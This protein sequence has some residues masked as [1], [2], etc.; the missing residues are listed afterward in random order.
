MKTYALIEDG[1]VSQLVPP[2]VNPDGVD[3]PVEDR[4]TPDMVAMMVDI[5]DMDP[6][7]QPGWT[8]DGT[9]FAAPVVTPP[10]NT[11]LAADARQQRD[12]LFRTVSDPGTLMAL[13]AVRLA[14]TPAETTYAQGKLAEMDAYAVALQ[15]IAEQAGFPV[16]IN[17]PT[18]PTV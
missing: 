9:T 16:T 18:I 13:R 14:T 2:Y 5:T 10:D 15:G 3:V 11:Q 6:Q 17:W 7:P 1:L 12:A 4:F 8:Y